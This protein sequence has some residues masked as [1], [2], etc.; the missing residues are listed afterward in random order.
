MILPELLI[1]QAIQAREFPPASVN[2]VIAEIKSIAP[3][4]WVSGTVISRNNSQ[5]SSEVSGRIV[6]LAE[7]GTRVNKDDVIAQI[8]DKVLRIKYQENDAQV[9][10]ARSQFKFQQ[11]EVQRLN[12]L[13]KRKLTSQKDIDSATTSRDIA[14]TYQLLP[15]F[16]S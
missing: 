16:C 2:I 4:A 3:I 6:Y 5:I 12:S 7:L 1:T 15:F 9:K 11:S 13:L 14:Q 8:D 10:N